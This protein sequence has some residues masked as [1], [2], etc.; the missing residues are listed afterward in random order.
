VNG[1]VGRS[2]FGGDLHVLPVER[3]QPV[4][5]V[6]R[7]T[8]ELLLLP[9]HH[10]VVGG[11]DDGRRG[12]GLGVGRRVERHVRPTE[13]AGSA[14][15]HAAAHARRPGRGRRFRA[16]GTVSVWGLRDC[17]IKYIVIKCIGNDNFMFFILRSTTIL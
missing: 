13:R 4:A 11:T 7:G 1:G 16:H 9:E 5:V 8:S 2:Q 3:R 14:V 15:R 17:D 10:V 12:R 6:D